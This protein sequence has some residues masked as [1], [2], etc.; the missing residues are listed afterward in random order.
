MK[1]NKKTLIMVVGLVLSLAV[2]L[3]GTL[4]YL[5]DT[6]SD[7]NVM[8]LGNVQIDQF[9]LQRKTDVAHN[10]EAGEGDLVLFVEGKPLYPA[11]ADPSVDKP[12]TAK[13]GSSGNAETMTEMFKWGDYTSVEMDGNGLWDDGLKG[14]VDKFVFVKNTGASDCYFRTWLAFE[15]P[16]G[17]D[18][19]EGS[20]KE[21]MMNVNA[22]YEWE[23]VGYDT[24]DGTR[25]LIY[26][27][28]YKDPLNKGT[29]KYILPAGE[30]ARPSL[31][32]VVMTHNATNDQMELLGE[33]YEVLAFTQA[34]QTNNFPD[35]H[36]ALEAAFKPAVLENH[37]WVNAKIEIPEIAPEG[38][39]FAEVT[40]LTENTTIKSADGEVD[41]VEKGLLIDTTDS[42]MGFDVGKVKMDVL[43]QFEPTMTAE[44]GDVS[45]WADWHADFVVSVNKDVP[46]YSVGLAGYYDAWCSLNNDKWVLLASDVEIKAGTEIR[47]VDAMGNGGITVAYRELCEYGNDGIGFLCGAVDLSGKMVGSETAGQ[48]PAGTT[49]TVELRLYEATGGSRDTETGNYITA[50]VYKYT[51]N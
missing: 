35:A 42:K 7:V 21:F 9:E 16:E 13:P 28:T 6:D 5:T 32:Q 22:A 49:I 37:P 24:I 8:T 25:Y 1:L 29:D 15:C 17:M 27:G 26:C 40:T 4:A 39:P 43:Y 19:S 20:D 10:A 3:G 33:T 45:E 18:Y 41:V 36:T 47:L 23:R 38:S 46:A 14:V 31:L 44:E 48:L 11:Y 34:C 51:F 12:Y 30:T 50:G 2:G